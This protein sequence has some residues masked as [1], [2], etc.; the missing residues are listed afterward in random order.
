MLIGYIRTG[1]NCPNEAQQLSL[2][3]E[4]GC[5]KIFN[6]KLDKSFIDTL[7]SGDTLVVTSLSMLSS[8]SI[9]NLLHI[10]LQIQE[11]GAYIK[12]LDE[13][14]QFPIFVSNQDLLTTLCNVENKIAHFRGVVA[15]KNRTKFGG[16][17][18]LDAD[19]VHQLRD[20]SRKLSVQDICKKLGIS[21]SSYYKYRLL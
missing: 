1:L 15:S 20:L 9:S 17:K 7:N 12:S 6:N 19:I 16:R 11:R 10:L 3:S 18:K 8:R 4:F 5:H 21:R 14:I 13:G 2:L